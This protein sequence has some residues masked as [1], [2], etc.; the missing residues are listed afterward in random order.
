MEPALKTLYKQ[1]VAELKTQIGVENVHEVPKLEKIV[2]NCSV[3]SQGERKQAIED[4]VNEVQ[5]ITGQKLS[6]ITI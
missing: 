6:L 1:K 4:A 5:L 3:G 2:L